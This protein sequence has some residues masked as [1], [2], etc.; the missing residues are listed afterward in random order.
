[1]IKELAEFGKRIRT[2]HDA[3]KDEPISIDLVIKEDGSFDSFL[4]IEKISRKAEALNSKKGK[5]RLLLDKAEEVLNY[6]G[7]NP[8]IL[9]EEKTV[10]QKKAQSATSFKHQLFLSKLQLY[11]EVEILTPVFA[12]YF[13]NKL[14]GLDKAILAFETQVGE[15]ERAGNIAFRMS[16]MR[17]HEQQFVYDAIIERFEKEQTQQLVGQKKCCSVCGKSDFPVVNQPHGLIKRIPDGQT[18]G[19]ALVSYNEKAFES[20]NLKGNDN[21]SICTNCAKNYVEGLN[22]LLANGSEKLIEDKKGN[23]KSQFV[24]SNRKNFGSDTAMIYWTKEEESTNELNLL[25][26]PDAGQVTNLID[27]VV[28]AKVK[29]AKYIKTNQFYSCTLSGAA[30]RIAIRDWIEI[31]LE[32]Y[33]RNIAK[34]FQDI[35]IRA[36]GETR[37]VPLYALARAGHNTKSSND[38]TNARVATQ[39]WDAALKNSVPPLWIL[40]AVLK[41]IRF[42]ENSE[43]GESKETITPERAALIRFVLNRNNLKGG[44]MIKEQNDPNDKSPAIVCGKIFAVMESIQRAAQG[45][46]LNAGIRERFFTSAS[47]NPATAFGRLM[48]LSQNHISKLKHEKPGLAVLLDRQL[49]ELCSILNGFPALFSLEEQG[50]FAL[51][52]Y[53]QKQQDYDNAKTNKEL[54][55]I[56]ET[57]EE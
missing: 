42:V 1:M 18:A 20:Y 31:S 41:R 23:A 13:S 4:V 56:I 22:W 7:V 47:T 37:Y 45:K 34:W 27:S 14:N 17:L 28:N 29:S 39:L 36:Y 38:P 49:Q 25:D 12:F 21:S 9:D 24:Y 8:E 19:C 40:T 26:N 16:D 35:A 48:K 57:K 11:K 55:S 10:A 51:G 3:L 2:G 53:H 46:D 44:T 32:D 30:A 6:S 15:K 52:Y 5:A 33:R 43:D 50:Q 54:Q